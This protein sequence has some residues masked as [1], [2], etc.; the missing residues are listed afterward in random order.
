MSF[1]NPREEKYTARKDAAATSSIDEGIIVVGVDGSANSQF[2]TVDS[3][4]HLQFDVL[5]LIDTITGI[6]H[7]IK[8]VTSAGTDEALAGSTS[9]KRVTIQ[10]QTDNT[11]WVAVGTSGVDATEATGNGVLLGA[12]DAFELEIDNL[13]DVFID[14]T[15]SGE[16]VRYTYFT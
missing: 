5:S 10:A 16:G 7:G 14:V 6:A 12:G 11:G 4:G 13:A 2:I 9:C 8:T 1:R 3:D 15:V